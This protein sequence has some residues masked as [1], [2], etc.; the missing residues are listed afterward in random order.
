MIAYLRR[1]NRFTKSVFGPLT[2][3]FFLRLR[4]RFLDFLVRMCRL[5]D[6]WKVISP[7]PVILNLFFAL[8]FVLTF[9]MSDPI[10]NYTLRA[11]HTG[12]N[13]WS[14]LGKVF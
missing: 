7:V 5:K 11:L 14:R 2:T 9:G 1:S 4:L 3:P 10:F 8:E 12:A 13:F 6:F